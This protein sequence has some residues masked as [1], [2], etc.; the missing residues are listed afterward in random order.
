MATTSYA[1]IAMYKYKQLMGSDL[2]Y[3]DTDSIMTTQKLP[4]PMVGKDL[5]LMKLEYTGVD[6]VF[7]APKVYAIKL[8]EGYKDNK[9]AT[10]G[11]YLFKVKGAKNHG[12]I[13]RLIRLPPL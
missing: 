13:F 12:W 11:G 1:R 10:L 2:L 7:L 5:G 9:G 8:A 4:D 3:T 6:A